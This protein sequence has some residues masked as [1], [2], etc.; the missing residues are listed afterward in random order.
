MTI[1]PTRAARLISS[2]R[3]S[4]VAITKCREKQFNPKHFSMLRKHVYS[5]IDM[6]K[7]MQV[8]C[9]WT[10]FAVTNSSR[11]S[12]MTAFESTC[13]SKRDCEKAAAAGAQKSQLFFTSLGQLEIAMKGWGSRQPGGSESSRDAVEVIMGCAQ[14]TTTISQ[15]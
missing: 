12:Y 8:G 2:V 9:S 1:P 15:K 13:L 4:C 5:M 10:G 11:Y 6:M 7:D 14:K 3:D